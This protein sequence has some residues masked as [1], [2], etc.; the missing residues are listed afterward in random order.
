MT[1]FGA[2]YRIPYYDLNSSLDLIAGYSDVASGTVQGLFNVSGS[3]TIAAARWNYLLPKWGEIEQ[4]LAFGLDYRAF[5]NEVTRSRAGNLHAR[6]HGAPASLTYSGLRRMTAADFP[7]T[8]ACRTTSPAAMTARKRT[9]A[10]ASR[11]GRPSPTTTSSCASGS[12]TPASS[13][14]NGRC[15]SASTASTP[16]DALVSGEQFGIGG[17]DSVRGYSLREVA[18]DWGYSGQAELYTPDFARTAQLSDRLQAA[19]P[20]V[21]RL[22]HHPAQ[23]GRRAE[24]FHRQHRAWAC[25]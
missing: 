23:Q 3:G 21:L 19:R 5:E 11:R 12:T 7:T 10:T 13:A 1:I 8:S 22:G 17:P 15:A 24:G 4:K 6:Y 18:N 25:A 16:S 20:G 14:T 2:G 9:G